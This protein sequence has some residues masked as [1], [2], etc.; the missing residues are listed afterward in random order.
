MKEWIISQT[1]S[2]NFKDRLKKDKQIM[3]EAK[4]NGN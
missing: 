2:K 4:G 1:K 3:K